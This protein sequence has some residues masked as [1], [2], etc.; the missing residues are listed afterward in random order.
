MVDSKK[1]KSKK[2]IFCVNACLF[3]LLQIVI[4]YFAKNLYTGT[5]YHAL[6]ENRTD[7]IAS[8]TPGNPYTYLFSFQRVPAECLYISP[9]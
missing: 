2:I 6:T 4:L 1:N 3:M 7:T 5:E 9:T 8:V